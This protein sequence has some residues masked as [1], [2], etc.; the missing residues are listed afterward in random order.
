MDNLKRHF[1]AIAL[2]GSALLMSGCESESFA[3]TLHNAERNVYRAA[4]DFANV[5]S[6]EDEESSYNTSSALVKVGNAG[7]VLSQFNSGVLSD[8]DPSYKI[9][10]DCHA[11]VLEVIDLNS[12]GSKGRRDQDIKTRHWACIK[13]SLPSPSLW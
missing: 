8:D 6:T 4:S 1:Q 13:S 5:L 11:K 12:Y 10:S 3:Q 2:T 9:A 7:E